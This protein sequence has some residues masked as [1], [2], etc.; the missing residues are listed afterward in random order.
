[1]SQLKLTADSGGGTIAIKAPASTTSNSAFE[2][3]LPGTGNRGLGKILQ[4]VN[5]TTTTE[6]STAGT[7][8]LDTNLTANITPTAASSK[9]LI[10][11]SQQLAINTN[12]SGNGG[13]LNI[14]RKVANGSFSVIEN[15]PA[16]STG[17]F[18]YFSSHGNATTL[19]LHLR[20][21]MTH[22]DSP[23]YTVGQQLTYKTQ[24]RIY[25]A[26]TNAM[27]RA[28]HA[29]ADVHDAISHII[30]MEVAA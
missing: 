30:L 10:N 5:A 24:M 13:G 18:S 12:D 14:L 9:I 21:N 20:H 26:A 23:S 2:L 27:L 15:S 29:A 7:T 8:F 17:P 3:T 22:L 4:V 11:I 25:Q 16:N 19:N 1:M 28:Q 6:A